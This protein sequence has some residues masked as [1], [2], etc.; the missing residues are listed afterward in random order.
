MAWWV[1]HFQFDRYHEFKKL[2][3]Q[4]IFCIKGGIMMI[5]EAIQEDES[6]L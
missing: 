5:I 6:G 4:D 3:E 1:L 2:R